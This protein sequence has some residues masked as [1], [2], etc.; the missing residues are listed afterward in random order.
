[1]KLFLLH[2][3]GGNVRAATSR[4]A[5]LQ[6]ASET[7]IYGLNCRHLMNVHVPVIDGFYVEL[8][9]CD[10][11]ARYEAKGVFARQDEFRVR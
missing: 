6:R 7:R 9:V 11:L 5:P 8:F 1:M 3:L 4:P 2:S 10:R